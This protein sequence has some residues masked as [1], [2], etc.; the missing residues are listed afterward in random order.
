MPHSYPL[1]RDFRNCTADDFIEA[2][3]EFVLLT[4]FAFMPIWLGFLFSILSRQE[5]AAQLFISDFLRSGEALLISAALVGPLIYVITR[6]Y[7]DLPKTL[8]IIFPQGWLFVGFIAII[9]VIAAALFGFHRTTPLQASAPH[10]STSYFDDN[11]IKRLSI[12]VLLAAMSILYL[13]S[14][15]RN[16][17]ERGAAALMHR[18]TQEFLREW[19]RQ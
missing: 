8:T 13:V 12:F 10:Q 16:Y 6:K 5:G 15:L 1:I 7:G 18:D 17:L 3:K 14:V 9:C 2:A 11:A 4:V 19:S